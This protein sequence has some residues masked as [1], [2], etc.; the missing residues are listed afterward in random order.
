MKEVLIFSAGAIV[1]AA[2][3]LLTA[4]LYLCSLGSEQNDEEPRD[5]ERADSLE[6]AQN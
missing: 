1:G 5:A 6:K 3:T 4:A 2:I